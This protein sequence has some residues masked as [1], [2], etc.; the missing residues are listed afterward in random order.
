M[1]QPQQEAGPQSTSWETCSCRLYYSVLLTE[2]GSQEAPPG[3]G[4][5]GAGAD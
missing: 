2:P 1:T 3:P 5:L 4:P